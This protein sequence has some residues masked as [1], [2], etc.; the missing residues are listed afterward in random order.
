MAG[1]E[2]NVLCHE[3]TVSSEK[4]MANTETR[5]VEVQIHGGG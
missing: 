4:A 5:L 2:G 3:F 1:V